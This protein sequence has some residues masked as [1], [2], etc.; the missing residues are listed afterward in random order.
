[1]CK[2][3]RDIDAIGF[4]V[5]LNELSRLYPASGCGAAALVLYDENADLNGLARA[6]DALRGEGLKA[7]AEC[8]FAGDIAYDRLFSFK[9]GTLTEV[10]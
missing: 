4:A 10:K 2:F 9:G 7:R 8:A 5:Y 1:M 6:M 3:G